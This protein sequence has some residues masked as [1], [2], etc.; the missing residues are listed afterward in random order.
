MQAG[1]MREFN[2]Y[3][4]GLNN[5]VARGRH[6]SDTTELDPE[7]MFT[8][9]MPPT[10][11]QMVMQDEM[12]GAYERQLRHVGRVYRRRGETETSKRAY[13][14]SRKLNQLTQIQALPHYFSNFQHMAQERNNA[15]H[16]A[17]EAELERI[18]TMGT[19]SPRWWTRWLGVPPTAADYKPVSARTN[20]FLRQAIRRSQHPLPFTLHATPPVQPW[21]ERLG[22]YGDPGAVF[23]K[24]K[25]ATLRSARRRSEK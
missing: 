11:R 14:M 1:R 12:A 22:R 3:V 10:P 13:L 15:S 25:Q 18:R 21:A 8:D 6:A 24:H 23:L 2:R 17:N 9:Q 19:P 7:P 4:H 20:E 16:E 5:Y